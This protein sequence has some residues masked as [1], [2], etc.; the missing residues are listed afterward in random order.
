MSEKQLQDAVVELARLH[1]WLIHHARPGTTRSGKWATQMQGHVGWVD[2]VLVKPPRALFCELKST[3]GRLSKH[4]VT[5]I[6]GL[7]A[8]GLDVRVWF[9]SDW[10]EIESTLAGRAAL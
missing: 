8:C 2:L 5:W 6:E 4:Q 9:P 1:G 3:R 10:D 7:R